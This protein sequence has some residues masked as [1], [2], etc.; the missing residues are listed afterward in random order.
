[1]ERCISHQQCQRATQTYQAHEYAYESCLTLSESPS[2][3]QTGQWT[4]SKKT[5]RILHTRAA[6]VQHVLVGPL[7]TE[8]FGT[9]NPQWP[10]GLT[11]TCRQSNNHICWRPGVTG[12]WRPGRREVDLLQIAGLCCAYLREIK[13]SQSMS[14]K[15]AWG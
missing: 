10:A 11:C 7:F 2:Q 6:R 3:G 9:G 8:V 5:C 4:W 12:I 1:M 13:Q 15:T 14:I